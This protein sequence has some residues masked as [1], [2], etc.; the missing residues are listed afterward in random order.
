MRPLTLR[1]LDSSDRTFDAELSRLI[2]Q[3]KTADSGIV[4][5][6]R[7]IISAV[8]QRGDSALLEYVARHDGIQA[9]DAASLR[10]TA[11][12]IS[13]RASLAEPRQRRA[14]E[15][16]AARIEAF[17]RKQKMTSWEFEQDG[18][19]LGQHIRALESVGIYIPGGKASYPSSVL[20]NAIPAMIAGVERIVAVTPAHDGELN[21]LVARALQLADVNE[22]YAMGGAQAIAALA[23]GTE[24]IAAVKKI[25]GPG[26]AYVAEAKRRVYGEVGIDMPAGPSEILI[27]SDGTT[28]PAWIARDLFSQAEHDEMARAILLCDEPDYFDEVSERM[29]ALI[30]RM[31]RRDII[32]AALKNHGAFI[33]VT[34][35]DEAVEVANRIAPEHLELSV[36]DAE[37]L[38]PKVR[39]AGAVFLGS[40][41]SEA[42][43]DY[44]AGPNHVLPTNGA[45][46]FSSPLGV[47]D[48]QKRINTLRCSPESAARLGEIAE[49]LAQAEGLPAHAEA[50]RARMAKPNR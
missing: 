40:Y 30:G 2:R 28:D 35:P 15:Q 33:K 26:N 34:S 49:C 32:A 16:A 5:T 4:D 46:H 39:N 17:A 38:L 31:P 6:V 50:A 14:L 48:F 13:A 12:Q 11:T 22:V 8:R 9:D 43:G 42:L 41:A 23:Y 27:I 36:K 24:T 25:T 7:E 44:C 1:R 10:V 47:Y 3:S 37:S 18:A 20:M 45:A 19:R 29:E 21:P